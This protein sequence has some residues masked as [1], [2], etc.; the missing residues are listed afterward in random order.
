MNFAHPPALLLLLL[1]VPV[2]LLYWLR[3]RVPRESVGTALFWQKALAEEE[4][5]RRWRPWRSRVSLPLELLI[6]TLLAA[7]AAGPQIPA[8]KSMVL[9]IDNSATMRATDVRP[10]RIDKAKETARQLI[11]NLRS[12]DTMA[13][14]A[15]SPEPSEVQPMTSDKALLAAAVD[16][17]QATA[18]PAAIDWAMKLARDIP[19][20]DTNP[21]RIVL[22]TDAC[23]KEAAKAA[24]ES[25]V[26]V[27]R[28]GT[29][30]G[31]LAITRFNARRSKDNPA[32]CEVLV[33]I[34][35]RGDQAA[36]GTVTLAMAEGAASASNSPGNEKAIPPEK[37]SIVHDGRWQ[38]VFDLDLP[39]AARLKA[40]IEPGDAYVFDDTA[41]LDVPAAPAMHDVRLDEIVGNHA[42]FSGATDIRS[43]SDA[44]R[45]ASALEL[46][47]PRQPLWI[48]PAAL[49]VALLVLE[50]CLYQRR[51]TT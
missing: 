50:S 46:P 49:A 41:S 40:N 27:L 37:F 15:S 17:I 33:E 48:A 3:L 21:P 11:E 31:N 1:L 20:P 13:V 26:E 16:S 5:R 39:T 12:C 42:A 43:P 14:V 29:A 35:N 18:Q 38:H 24:Q 30:A 51:W 22:V 23:S 2:V 25:G 7:A 44:G 47:K 4:F 8:S 28:V 6:V 45:E 9:V 32:K 36:D 19:S 10:A 34:Q